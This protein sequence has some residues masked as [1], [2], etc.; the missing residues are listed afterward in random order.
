MLQFDQARRCFV[1]DGVAI[2]RGTRE[3]DVTGRFDGECADTPGHP[4][5]RTF[6]GRSG[7]LGLFL[8]FRSGWLDN[9]YFA[10]ALLRRGTWDAVEELEAWRR[11]RHE[12]IMQS[13]FGAMRFDSSDLVVDL[14]REP[15]NL[16]EQLRFVVPRSSASWWRRHV[17][18]TT[19]R[20]GWWR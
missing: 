8:A 6:D 3:R 2:G 14:V 7:E 13:L 17:L 1:L 12:A 9:G 18:T 16:T 10:I 11:Q 20:F 19:R 5:Y 4:D 15:R